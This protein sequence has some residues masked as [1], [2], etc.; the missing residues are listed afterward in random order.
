KE[1]RNASVSG[2]RIRTYERR[3]GTV[4]GAGGIEDD[5]GRLGLGKLLAV[6]GIPQEGDRVGVGV[7]ER[8]GA[9]DAR[10]RITAQLASEADRE[11]PERDRH[12]GSA[13]KARSLSGLSPRPA[14]LSFTLRLRRRSS[15]LAGGGRTLQSREDLGGDVKGWRR[16]DD[17]VGHHE[18]EILGLR[19]RAHLFDQDALQARHLLVAAGVE[20]V[21]CLALFALQVAV[22]VAQILLGARALILCHGRAVLLQL[23]FLRLQRLLLS[24]KIALPR[25]ELTADLLH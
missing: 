22:A 12:V 15:G 23:V 13:R 6:A 7:P 24:G 21:L 10:I 14:A 19:V 11:L 5:R 16:I 4:G 1:V 8:S 2:E 3:N 20:V 17:P 25:R 18:I 9:L